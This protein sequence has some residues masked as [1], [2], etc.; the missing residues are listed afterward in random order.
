VTFSDQICT[1]VDRYDMLHP[2]DRIGV[3]VSGGADSL[4][5]LHVLVELR[6]KYNLTLSVIHID[7]GLRGAQSQA[8]AQ[9][10][11]K[12]AQQLGLPFHL[13]TL[14]LAVCRGNLE[15]EAR[16]ARYQF[17]RD[18]MH[19]GVVQRVAL[20]HTRSDQ[21]ETVL[22]R[23]LRGAGSGGLAGIRPVTKSGIIRPLLQVTR[24]QVVEWLGERNLSWCEDA[25]NQDLRFDRNRIRYE[26]IPRLEAEWN[27]QLSGILA[28]TADWALAEDEYWRLEIPR[29]TANWLRF[30][31]G[32]VIVN[33][34]Q[35][36]VLP[37]AV[38][39]RVIREAIEQ[40]KGD[41]LSVDF[42]HIEKV[43]CLAGV[44]N[45]EGRVQIPGLEV[46]RSF[47]WLRFVK[48]PDATVPL[49]VYLS[50]TPNNG[51]YNE[52]GKALDW[53]KVCR[54]VERQPGAAL[55]V[56]TW[57]P[58]DQYQRRGRVGA[59]KLKKLFQEYRIPSWERLNW[60]IVAVGRTVAW[61]GEFG[62]A[63]EF[64]VDTN[65]RTVLRIGWERQS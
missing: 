53:E 50:L 65:S 8:D 14:D 9:F 48:R 57:R 23:L 29:L 46:V 3:A 40:V 24:S 25:T 43:R 56:R 1:T 7:H 11:H 37:V 6:S 16:R 33:A 47:N 30:A 10:V 44:Q 26:L 31:N 38:V 15:Q 13:R 22:F 32:A 63:A 51:V 28:Q 17:F 34:D 27:P 35:L 62:P 39:R 55:I 61:A 36:N 58:G 52:D 21:A 49:G 2:G 19:D 54:E 18:L 64:A 60:P 45:G 41:L 12:S 20:G 4:C 59:E 42:F 5:L